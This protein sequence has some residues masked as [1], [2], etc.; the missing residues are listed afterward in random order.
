[1]VNRQTNFII[2]GVGKDMDRVLQIG[3]SSV[4]EIPVPCIGNS[5][6]E[7][8]KTELKRIFFRLFKIKIGITKLWYFNVN[9][10]AP[11]ILT[12][13]RMYGSG[14][15]RQRN[16]RRQNPTATIQCFP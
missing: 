16:F 14:F 3:K 6:G 10:I 7:I 12:C 1:M 8:S 4:A 2:S 9:D 15:A 13:R 5:R 11:G